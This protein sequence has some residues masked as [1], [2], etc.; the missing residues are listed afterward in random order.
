MTYG[1]LS[2]VKFLYYAVQ[3]SDS[4]LQIKLYWYLSYIFWTL[5]AN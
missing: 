3:T 5:L 2:E 1:S 4:A